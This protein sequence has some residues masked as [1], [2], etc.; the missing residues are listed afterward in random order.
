MIV[1]DYAIDCFNHVTNYHFGCSPL[2]NYDY[3]SLFKIRS[4]LEKVLK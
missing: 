3:Q 4:T 1:I 2:F